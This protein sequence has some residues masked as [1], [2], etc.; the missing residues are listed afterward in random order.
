M[1][2]RLDLATCWRLTSVAKITCLAK[3]GVVFKSFS[4]IPREISPMSTPSAINKLTFKG[5]S[6]WLPGE[7]DEGDQGEGVPMETEAEAAGHALTSTPWRSGKRTR[8]SSSSDTPLDAFQV[9]LE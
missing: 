2:W 5:I 8:A 6:V 4:V 9:I 1:F 3:I 7:E